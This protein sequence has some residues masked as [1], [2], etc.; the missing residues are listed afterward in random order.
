MSISL[1]YPVPPNA[2]ISQTFA[3]HVA[4]GNPRYFGGID[5]AVPT[6]TPIRAAADGKVIKASADNTGYGNHIR[7]QHADGYMTLY[8]H[9]QDYAVGVGA[10]VKAGDVIGRSDNTGNS[11]GPHL[12]F[13]VRLNGV[14]V[15][16]APM[17]EKPAPAPTPTGQARLLAGYN[18][19]SS[20]EMAN[21]II[22]SL[23]TAGSATVI[24][25]DGDWVQI[26]VWIHKDGVAM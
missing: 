23:P 25:T 26:E 21:N 7:V 18:L 11:T 8:G 16:P 24:G 12:H 20:P 15:D 6:G 13:E 3:E 14:P 17:L 2:P 9:L 4:H 10:V 19:R 1:L 5:W 22:A